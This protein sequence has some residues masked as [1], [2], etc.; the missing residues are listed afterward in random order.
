MNSRAAG[1]RTLVALL[2]GIAAITVLD[3]LLGDR[4]QATY[5]YTKVALNVVPMVACAAAARGFAPGDYLRRGW[6]AFAVGY[7]FLTMC[8]IVRRWPFP[9]EAK[10]WVDQMGLTVGSLL[11]TYATFIFAMA[12]RAAG[13]PVMVSRWR[14]LA[15]FAG[16]LVV[17]VFLTKGLIVAGFEGV[18][19][20][21]PVVL[22][23]LV[24]PIC[25][26]VSFVVF[27]PLALTTISLRGG[28]L[29]WVYGLLAFQTFGWMVN[30]ASDELAALVGVSAAT[31]PLMMAG[32]AVGALGLI[33]AAWMQR[34]ATRM[35][36]P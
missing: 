29:A 15:F 3:V 28:A 17:A 33:G 11:C 8:Q 24:S 12:F 14:R 10:L 6:N 19:R 7:L 20:E 4:A 18:V 2:V 36:A 25:D 13:L 30:E 26:L 1:T 35:S 27:V 22:G 21:G 34:V 23:D 16:G 32:F 5:A 9:A 31:R